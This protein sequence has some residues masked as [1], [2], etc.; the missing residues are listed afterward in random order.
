MKSR[1]E[2]TV[3]EPDLPELSD[4][5]L[6][7]IMGGSEY[8][9]YEQ[10]RHAGE[11][12]QQGL[13]NAANTAREVGEALKVPLAAALVFATRTAPHPVL[14]GAAAAGAYLLSR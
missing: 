6:S 10:L 5:E 14:Q 12:I 9:A 13:N 11:Q 1:F 7:V 3:S 2:M 8:V 4:A